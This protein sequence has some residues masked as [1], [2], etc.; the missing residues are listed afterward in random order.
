MFFSVWEHKA[1]KEMYKHTR[2]HVVLVAFM[3]AN[4][5]MPSIIR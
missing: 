3:H 2:C 5:I 4:V 1:G